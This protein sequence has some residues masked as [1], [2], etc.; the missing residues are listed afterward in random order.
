MSSG[1]NETF[2]GEGGFTVQQDMG[3]VAL[4]L[5]LDTYNVTDSLQ[6]KFSARRMN[7]KLGITKDEDNYEVLYSSYDDVNDE[8]PQDMVE[9]IADEILDYLNTDNILSMGK[10]STLYSD[11]NYTVME[12]FGAPYGFSNIFAAEKAYTVNQ[13]VFDASAL[14]QLLHKHT[15]DIS[16]SYVSDLS[17]CFKVKNINDHLRYLQGADVFDN[18]PAQF[19]YGVK[20]GFLHGDLVYIPDGISITL[21]VDIEEEPYAPIVNIGPSNLASI[22]DL[23]NYTNTQTLVDKNTTYSVSNITQ[24]Y[25]VPILIILT[26]DEKF[27]FEN[28]GTDWVDMTD[29]S[30]GVQKWLAVSISASGKYQTA[31]EE[32]GDIYVSNDYGTTW[33]IKHNIGNALSNCI[34]ISQSGQYQ[35]AS[36]GISI[37]VSSDYGETWTETYNLGGSNIF[38]RVS[39]NGQ[40]QTIVSSGDS[41]YQSS[42]FGQTWTRYSDEDSNIYNSISMFPTGGL[43]MSYDGRYQTIASEDIYISDDYGVTWSTANLNSLN[44]DWEDRNWHGIAISSDGKYQTAIEVIGEIYVSSDYGISWNV[45]EELPIQDQNWQDIS[46]SANGRYQTAVAKGGK[47]FTSTTFGEIWETPTD[48]DVDKILEWQSLKVSS[49]GQYQTGVVYNGNI[50][51]SR[52][53]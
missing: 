43:S 14:L 12:Y 11:F 13:G 47:I 26:N 24:T 39:L 5:P 49:N 31:I 29:D 37:F 44:Q 17:G 3:T 20:E 42:D 30:I 48:V 46:I 21:K 28:Y 8:Q 45:K 34:S 9:I 53:I 16:G 1:D 22:D 2:T 40:Y 10:L 15:F 7:D 38:V 27:N 41:F 25:K 50:Y 19:N 35:T 6:I 51:V 4:A 32:A 52:L 33:I 18:R 36:N 23:F